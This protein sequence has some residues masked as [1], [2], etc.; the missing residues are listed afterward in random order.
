V[1]AYRGDLTAFSRFL[2]DVA[3][4]AI[5]ADQI[6]KY[7]SLF[8]TALRASAGLLESSASSVIWKSPE[9]LDNPTRR[10]RLPKREH[11]LPSV[12]SDKEV[13]QLIGEQRPKDND[14]PGW[15]DRALVETLYSCGLRA[16][17]AVALNWSD[18]DPEMA[19]VRI[20]HG[21]GDKFRLIPIG[22]VA[23]GVARSPN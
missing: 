15:R 4:E 21:K 14:R 12:V 5:T 9:R 18:I 7:L 8:Q 11:R 2:G 23:R 3:V 22:E 19:M 17:E 1:A 10:M 13:E 20:L 16:G 6:R